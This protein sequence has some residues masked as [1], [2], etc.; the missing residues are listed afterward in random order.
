LPDLC[1]INDQQPKMLS[2]F[3]KMAIDAHPYVWLF[4]PMK[5]GQTSNVRSGRMTVWA[6]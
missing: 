6:S 3:D 4:Q 2:H 5:V 1:E